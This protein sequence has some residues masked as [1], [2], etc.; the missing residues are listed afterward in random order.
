MIGDMGATGGRP[1]PAAGKPVRSPSTCRSSI[2]SPRTTSGGARASPSGSTSPR[3]SRS[4]PAIANPTCPRELGYY[5][6]RVPEVR[7]AQAA[8]AAEHGIHGF[9]YYHYWF[10]GRRLLE[11][12]FDEVL[13]SGSP[14]FP[15]ALCWANEE[16]TR[17]WDAQTGEVLMP[18]EFSDEDDLAHIRWLCTAFKDDRYIKIDGRP[19]MLIYRPE[20]LPDPSGPPRS[21]GPRRRG[22]G[23]P[24][25]TSAGSR[26]WGPPPGGPEA[27]GLDASVGFMPVEARRRLRSHSRRPRAPDDR[28]PSARSKRSSATSLL[29]GNG[30][31][32]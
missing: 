3:R 20:Q 29:S 32:R 2:R 5:D 28:L 19:L 22:S 15:F 17:N 24:T 9:V 18:Q 8:L 31:P 26:A 16:W 13:A 6:L 23:S 12:P 11:R 10:H 1:G 25:S 21:G 7:E 30:S 27:F 14:D 4:S